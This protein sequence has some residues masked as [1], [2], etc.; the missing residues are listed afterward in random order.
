VSTRIEG[1][2]SNVSPVPTAS[3]HSVPQT[4]R[5]AVR[6]RTDHES[7]QGDYSYKSTV[8]L[9]SALDEVNGWSTPRPGRFTPG[10]DLLIIV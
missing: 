7:R 4:V 5:G 9:T 8:L 1:E 10:K 3:C 6:S 2:R